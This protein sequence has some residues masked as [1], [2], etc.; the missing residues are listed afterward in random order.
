MGLIL[1]ELPL[2]EA[3]QLIM[4]DLSNYRKRKQEG[5]K[6][7]GF[8]RGKDSLESE[9]KESVRGGGAAMRKGR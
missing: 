3:S 2:F 9:H 8:E 6:G 7:S 4:D 1:R 5:R